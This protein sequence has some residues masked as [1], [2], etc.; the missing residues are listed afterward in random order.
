[1]CVVQF[2]NNWDMKVRSNVFVVSI[3]KVDVIN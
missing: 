1:M 3:Y 2:I